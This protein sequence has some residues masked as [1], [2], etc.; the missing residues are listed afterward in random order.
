MPATLYMGHPPIP[1]RASNQHNPSAQKAFA[2]GRASW[3]LDEWG[4][5]E[6]AAMSESAA[7]GQATIY[8]PGD[9]PTPM[10][11][12]LRII[13]VSESDRRGSSVEGTQ[14]APSCVGRLLF[15]SSLRSTTDQDTAVSIQPS[16]QGDSM[17]SGPN[18]QIQLQ[19]GSVLSG[20]R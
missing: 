19:Q 18:A 17:V 14:Y 9:F 8:L 4:L 1:N 15:R 5:P 13:S 3:H 11:V 12:Q 7:D 6:G 20:H 10:R 2:D 16:F